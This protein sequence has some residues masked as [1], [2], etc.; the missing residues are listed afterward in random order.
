[1]LLLPDEL[2]SQS[3]KAK[4]ESIVGSDLVE[5]ELP[6][7]VQTPFGVYEKGVQTLP[8]FEALSALATV[9]HEEN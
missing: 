1:M 3:I 5:V 8:R 2:D 4:V 9:A 7:L 6:H